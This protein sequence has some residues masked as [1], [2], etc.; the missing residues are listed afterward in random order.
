MPAWPAWPR[1]LWTHHVTFLVS[2]FPTCKIGVK[3]LCTLRAVQMSDVTLGKP[4]DLSAFLVGEGFTHMAAGRKRSDFEQ[5]SAEDRPSCC[6]S[7]KH[8]SLGPSRFGKQAGRHRSE[9]QA[10]RTK[11]SSWQQQALPHSLSWPLA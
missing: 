4:G 2:G 5:L 7:H 10:S 11:G 3:P 6:L 9:D 1:W 8:S